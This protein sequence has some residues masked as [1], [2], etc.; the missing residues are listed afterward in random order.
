MIQLAENKNN[1]CSVLRCAALPQLLMIFWMSLHTLLLSVA[2]SVDFGLHL[3]PPNVERGVMRRGSLFI[4]HPFG[5][6]SSE[7]V[8]KLDTLFQE[9]CAKNLCTALALRILSFQG[10][11]K[12][13]MLFVCF[14]AVLDLKN[15]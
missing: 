10:N 2:I 3:R 11:C 7:S 8:M 9:N 6:L 13:L 5:K 4:A 12:C 15:T 1:N 14:S